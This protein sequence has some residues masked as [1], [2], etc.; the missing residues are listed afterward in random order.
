MLTPTTSVAATSQAAVSRRSDGV[1]AIRMSPT[2]QTK[3]PL[4]SENVATVAAT[5][6]TVYRRHSDRAGHAHRA[7]M[8]T[9]SPA[10]LRNQET[11]QPHSQLSHCTG[12]KTRTLA[13]TSAT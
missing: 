1:A 3:V 8:A 5:A 2:T 13:S 12:E 4:A 9:K 7:Q 6:A 10:L 11:F